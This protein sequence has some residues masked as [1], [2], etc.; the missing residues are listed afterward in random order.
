ML[1]FS[2][3]PYRFFCFLILRVNPAE[4]WKREV[5]DICFQERDLAKAQV[6]QFWTKGL[7]RDISGFAVLGDPRAHHPCPGSIAPS[8]DGINPCAGA[9]PAGCRGC[10]AL[11]CFGSSSSTATNTEPSVSVDLWGLQV[12]RSPSSRGGYLLLVPLE[13]AGRA[14]SKTSWRSAENKR[15]V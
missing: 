14:F 15:P 3:Y 4:F 11:Q 13:R 2:I 8:R 12:K 1:S 6:P 7:L 10:A 5:L 9:R